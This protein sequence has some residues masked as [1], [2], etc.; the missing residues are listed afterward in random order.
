MSH[1]HF[2]GLGVDQYK[3]LLRISTGSKN[4]LPAEAEGP[5]VEREPGHLGVGRS[6]KQF[7]PDALL[8]QH[9]LRRLVLT[10]NSRAR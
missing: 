2:T 3:E 7:M 5:G 8:L 10:I 6:K 9:A 4:D 1:Q